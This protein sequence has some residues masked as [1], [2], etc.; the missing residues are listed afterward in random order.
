VRVATGTPSKPT[1]VG[2]PGVTN[3]VGLSLLWDALQRTG[4]CVSDGA[5]LVPIANP[6]EDEIV[7]TMLSVARRVGRPVTDVRGRVRIDRLVPRAHG[8]ARANSLSGRFGRGAFPLHTDLAH[9]VMPPRFLILGAAAAAH[10]AA[11]T[12]LTQAPVLSHDDWCTVRDGVFLVSNGRRSFYTSICGS[13]CPFVRFD[14]SSMTPTDAQASVAQRVFCDRLKEQPTLEIT[15]ER[16]HM[17]VVDN[18]HMLHGRTKAEDDTATRVL[19]RAYA[20]EEG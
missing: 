18:W 5:V 12:T 17:L 9:R 20:M 6:T 15:W 16:G 19:L 13:G 8:E 1:R 3:A 14:L 4:D 10:G 2:N 11:R 7:A